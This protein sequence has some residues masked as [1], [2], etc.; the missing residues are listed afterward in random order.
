MRGRKIH[1][2]WIRRPRIGGSFFVT[3]GKTITLGIGMGITAYAVLVAGSALLGVRLSELDQFPGY[4]ECLAKLETPEAET[5]EKCRH[6]RSYVRA[7]DGDPS[8]VERL[9]AKSVASANRFTASVRGDFDETVGVRVTPIV[10]RLEMA[11]RVA[12]DILAR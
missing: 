4:V 1:N 3:T 8:Y 6:L 10:R 11:A 7:A 5:R 12:S 9:A 2:H